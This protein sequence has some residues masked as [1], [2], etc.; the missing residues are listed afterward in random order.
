MSQTWFRFDLVNN[1]IVIGAVAVPK[2]CPLW[3][4]ARLSALNGASHRTIG[5]EE[6]QPG[7]FLEE[8][9]LQNRPIPVFRPLSPRS[10]AEPIFVKQSDLDEAASKLPKG[11]EEGKIRLDP[12]KVKLTSL[13]QFQKLPEDEQRQMHPIRPESLGLQPRMV[14]VYD[15][16][17]DPKAD[18]EGSFRILPQAIGSWIQI[19]DEK[20]V[21]EIA[22]QTYNPEDRLLVAGG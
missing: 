20:A 8:A 21:S 22:K 16:I 12:R 1:A 14:L 2:E 19:R 18:V 13:A 11:G 9:Y 15:A 6:V 7:D 3:F 4:S 10:V 5:M 17:V